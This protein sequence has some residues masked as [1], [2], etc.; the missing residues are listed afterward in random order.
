M[1]LGGGGYDLG[2]VAC[3]WTHETAIA[4][5]V[6]IPNGKSMSADVNHS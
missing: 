1:L 5:G 6:R 4:I 3:C 2:N